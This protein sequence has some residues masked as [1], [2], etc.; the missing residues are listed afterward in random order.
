[1][2]EYKQKAQKVEIQELPIV[3]LKEESKNQCPSLKATRQR[4]FSYSG[5]RQ[6]VYSSQGLHPI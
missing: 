4:I 3:Q 6:P 1:V 5:K 2:V